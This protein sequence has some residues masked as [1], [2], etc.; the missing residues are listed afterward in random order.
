M[1]IP[2]AALIEREFVIRDMQLTKEVR[3]TKKSLIR[4]LALALGL[5]S[6]NESRKT[7]LDLLEALFYFQ[8]SEN[9]D[10]DAHEIADY[11]RQNHEEAI[12]SEKTILYHLLQLKN[13]G[14]IRR[15]KGKYSFSVSPYSEKG[16]VASSIEYNYKGRSDAAFLKIQEALRSLR[17]MYKQK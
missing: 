1:Q 7:I 8:F 10:P 5:I 4:W 2:E 6:Q 12:V 17:K 11:M 9:K 13:A 15:E 14:L 16:D 3:M